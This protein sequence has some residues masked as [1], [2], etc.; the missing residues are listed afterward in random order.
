MRAMKLRLGRVLVVLGFVGAVIVA[1]ALPT[2]AADADAG[3][4]TVDV[5]GTVAMAAP[6]VSGVYTGDVDATVH[7]TLTNAAEQPT[8]GSADVTVPAPLVVRFVDG[9]PFAGGAT[10]PL[11]A[12][13]LAAG[14]SRTY[15]LTV[16]VQTCVATPPA[17]LAVVAKENADF[18]GDEFTLDTESSDGL[19]DLVGV[20]RPAF[21]Q[22]PTSAERTEAIT[23]AA[24]DPAAAGI[25]V[26]LRDAGDTGRASS[27][28]ATISLTAARPGVNPAPGLAGTTSAA[29]ASGLATFSPGPTLAVSA[30]SYTLTASATGLTD[31]MP[32][33]P[34]HIV[35]SRAA[36]PTGVACATSANKSAQS[37]TVTMNSG[38]AAGDLLLSLD[39]GDG[40]DFECP[41]YPRSG[42]V[43]SQY[44]FTGGDGRLGTFTYK[45]PADS[46]PLRD[47]EV[48][49]AA[50]YPFM[51]KKFTT[52]QIQGVKPGTTDPLW[53]GV[54]PNCAKTGPTAPCVSARKMDL[55]T[56]I[57]T[58][59]VLASS[60][61]PWRY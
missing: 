25:T 58:L 57:V 21:V 51:N 16:D 5:D 7:L 52:A 55:V 13:G 19:V 56:R 4:F 59:S 45:M 47:Y 32:S 14:A 15:V 35:D 39:A 36:C 24:F 18:T 11:R 61:D 48:C 20:C 26:E 6:G 54:L 1:G 37:I 9:V 42:Q 33:S 49:W 3:L 43:V 60:A 23:R 12:I 29:T 22:Q 8:L 46:R 28:S 38:A 53:V 50:P 34:F 10:V 44:L 27:A 40:P 31:S 2:R 17:E 30:F 41:E